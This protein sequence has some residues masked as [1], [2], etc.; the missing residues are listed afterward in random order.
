MVECGT[1]DRADEN[2]PKSVETV[3][4][5]EDASAFREKVE[6]DFSFFAEREG[7]GSGDDFS[8]FTDG[9]QGGNGDFSFFE[10]EGRM[11]KGED[12]GEERRGASGRGESVDDDVVQA[13]R[14]VEWD[15]ED[16][17]S[18]DSQRWGRLLKICER[19]LDMDE[20]D[21]GSGE[22]EIR[23]ADELR[24]FGRGRIWPSALEYDVPGKERA[25][26][27]WSGRLIVRNAR[28]G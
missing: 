5:D 28:G 17:E 18:E 16:V 23:T 1:I 19:S 24:R 21:E 25:R 27:D 2:D 3:F 26:L 15:T 13:G 6:S 4:G 7:V 10:G 9:A 12:A 11:R 8:F 22:R 20:C 14:C